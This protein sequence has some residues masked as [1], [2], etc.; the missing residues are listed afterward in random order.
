MMPPSRTRAR[1]I[2]PVI[3][4]LLTVI[5]A[6]VF[7]GCS[8]LWGESIISGK[9][10]PVPEAALIE[11]QVTI[12]AR[13]TDS[14]SNNGFEA[15]RLWGPYNDW[16]P[17]IAIDRATGYVYQLTTRYDGPEPCKRCA[18]P[19][20]IFRRS[21]DGGATLEADQFLTPFRK[22]H[23][24][25]QIEV[26]GDG[27]IYAVWLNDYVPG[28]KFVKSD[29]CGMTWTAPITI[30]TKSTKPNWSDK[31]VLAVSADGRDVYIAFNAS[32][33]FVTVSHD[34]GATFSA[35]V[36]TSN[37]KRYW[38]HTGGAVAP[39]GSVYFAVTDY[40]LDYT[41]DAHINILKSSNGGSAWSTTRL[42]T[43]KEAPRCD[44]SP[45]CYL[46][47]FG[48]SAVLAIDAKGTIMLAYN[49]GDIAGAE[50]R[51]WV[52]TS[53]DGV[54]WSARSEISN[55]SPTVNNAFPALAAG[56]AAGDF[57]IAWQDD[58]LGSR[59]AWNTWYRRTTD[60]GNNWIE[61]VRV[62]DRPNG[63]PYKTADG[64][65][66]PYGD[67]FEIAIDAKSRTHLIW[68]EGASYS[69]PGGT[70]YTR[71]LETR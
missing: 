3:L 59:I 48:P 44:W 26:A 68:G 64:Y 42:D 63:A 50:Q 31:P 62:S 34:S 21:N 29:D 70:W 17:A 54:N 38:F 32:D 47:F 49:A 1:S 23:N 7:F 65:A 16:E 40:S 28:V 11:G 45:G 14:Q 22:S 61:P 46:G 30:T 33:S 27:T 51:M 66:F 9:R 56:I 41:G 60:G 37:D 67:Y 19:Y 13:P 25:P 57:R 20:I 43:S 10:R 53:T 6:V 36:R 12:Q 18:G 39:D 58:R 8:F 2:R 71:E 69:G 4:V 24:D 35:P 52:R 55:R 15:E 5:G